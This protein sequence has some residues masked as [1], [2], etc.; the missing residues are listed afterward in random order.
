MYQSYVTYAYL[1]FLHK[2][3]LVRLTYRVD[4]MECGLTRYFLVCTEQIG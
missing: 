1:P 3:V 4:P 2:E